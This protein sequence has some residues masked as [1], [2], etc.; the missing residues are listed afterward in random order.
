M[1]KIHYPHHLPY[2]TS[3]V[4]H[5]GDFVFVSGVLPF[6]SEGQLI[7]GTIEQQTTVV[8]ETI[9]TTLGEVNCTLSD[10]VKTT[11]WLQDPR[12]FS[13]FNKV[14]AEFFPKDPP[15]RVTVRADLMVD[16]KIEIESLAYKPPD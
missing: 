3:K 4:V 9:N 11:V 13:G 15:T 1:G 16:A 8:L 6:D 10:I 14:Y 12:D 5:A 7:P 2:P